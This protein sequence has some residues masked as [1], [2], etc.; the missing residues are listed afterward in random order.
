MHLCL[1]LCLARW[2]VRAEK[3]VPLLDGIHV[4]ATMLTLDGNSLSG[5]AFPASWLQQG[6]IPGLKYLLLSNNP[7]LI[8][9]LPPNLPWPRMI[10]L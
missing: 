8:G 6:A 10:E 1:A 3:Q 5:P 9:T 4:Q 7:G 2:C